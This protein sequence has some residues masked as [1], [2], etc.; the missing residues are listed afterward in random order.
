MKVFFASV[1]VAP[2]A[3]AG[4][5]GDVAGSL[6]KALRSL[7][8]D[9]RVIMPKHR[10]AAERAGE[11]RRAVDHCPVHMPWWV[12]G[13][14][15]DETRLPGTE[16][17]VYMVEHNQYFD[18][19]GIYGPPG[20]S[21]GDNLER[22]AFFCRSVV[23]CLQGLR[24]TPDV[25]HLNDWHTSLVAL[26]QKQWDLGFCTAYTAHQLGQ[27]YHGRFP[28]AQQQ[29][30]GIDLGRPEAR[31]FVRDGEID[32]ARAG[33]AMA[34]VANTVSP[35]YAREVAQEGS[36]EGV[37]DLVR[38]MG[39]RFQGILNGIDYSTW[40]PA[41]D[42]AIA[43]RY[44]R[45]DPSGKVECKRALR[46]ELNLPDDERVPLVVMI[47]RLDT[48]K[49]FDLVL[50]V[51]PRLEGAQFV[52]LGSGDLRYQAALEYAARSREDVRAVCRFD[53]QLS[54]R[55]YAGGDVLLMPSRRE[56]AG[57]TQMIALAYGTIP[58]VHRTGGL[59]DTVY[60]SED[61][62]NGF[63]F[64]RYSADDFEAALRRA[65]TAYRD[66]AKWGALV[67]RAMGCDFSWRA[68]AE[69]YVE[70]YETALAAR[71]RGGG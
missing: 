27:A 9:V 60:E 69:K 37:W 49:G 43:V 45:E 19:E 64:E 39:D 63:V 55:V 36:E 68:S 58:V 57:L 20:G 5:M 17:P 53:P 7:G 18:R 4:G 14:A 16:V 67:E 30:A 13:C 26:Y 59:A 38:E 33:L 3:W 22:F 51:L 31:R 50:E 71:R 11:V 32:L 61:G 10:G 70:M 40:N 35:Q 28:A 47:S 41:T 1:E 21:F 8:V 66:P 24:W 34:D 56:P 42:E 29:L 25:V 52:F 12:T 65:L 46:A 2:F 15:V 44:S 62:G 6:P 48:I 23:E 54:R